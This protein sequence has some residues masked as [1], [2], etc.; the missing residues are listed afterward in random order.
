M[1]DSIEALIDEIRNLRAVQD[2][3]FSSSF[4]NNAAEVLERDGFGALQLFLSEKKGRTELRRQAEALTEV[5]SLM[6]AH[7]EVYQRRAIGRT[8]IKTLSALKPSRHRI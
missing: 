6:R 4:L 7:P 8:L 3:R 1:K 5:A 2:T